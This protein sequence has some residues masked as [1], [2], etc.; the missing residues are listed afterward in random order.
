MTSNQYQEYVKEVASTL[1]FSWLQTKPEL[2]QTYHRL[3]LASSPK[4]SHIQVPFDIPIHDLILDTQIKPSKLQEFILE[5]LVPSAIVTFQSLAEDIINDKYGNFQSISSRI[6]QA[7][8]N[9]DISSSLA[10]DAHYWRLTRNIIAHGGGE[11]S[12]SVEQEIYRLHNNG[13]ISFTEF[14][15]WGKLLDAGHGGTLVPIIKEA[16]DDPLNPNQN[17]I[18][19]AAIA[20]NR[21]EL[22]MADLLAAGMT[23]TKY[24]KAIE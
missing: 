3:A 2:L 11:I 17:P 13:R 24:I 5:R 22:G 4:T 7:K 6:N 20:G 14:K 12:S 16:V 21:I 23:W 1:S 15:F 19:V 8:D 18:I 9:G 10:N